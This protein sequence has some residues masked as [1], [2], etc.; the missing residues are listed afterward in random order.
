MVRWY[1]WKG[2]IFGIHNKILGR[3]HSLESR[4][5]YK[6]IIKIGILK[7]PVNFPHIVNFFF[8]LAIVGPCACWRQKYFFFLSNFFPHNLK[9]HSLA[10]SSLQKSWQYVTKNMSYTYFWNWKIPLIF[11]RHCIFLFNTMLYF[12]KLDFFKG[13]FL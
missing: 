2:N 5:R 13:F 4:K 8:W 11:V 1:L 7:N 9:V 12:L 10:F 3:N 6:K